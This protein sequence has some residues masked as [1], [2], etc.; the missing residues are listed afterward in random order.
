M[1]TIGP[2]ECLDPLMSFQLLEIKLL[3][4]HVCSYPEHDGLSKLTIEVIFA[5]IIGSEADEISLIGL[6]DPKDAVLVDA[7]IF[8]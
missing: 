7:D 3:E 2:E 8:M 6:I 1:V 5:L 4:R